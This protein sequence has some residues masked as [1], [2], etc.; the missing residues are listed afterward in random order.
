VIY[1]CEMYQFFIRDFSS[2][3]L[4]KNCNQVTSYA[5]GSSELLGIQIDAAINP[6][7]YI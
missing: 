6:G 7:K 4:N 1:C 3:L 2:Q 5:H